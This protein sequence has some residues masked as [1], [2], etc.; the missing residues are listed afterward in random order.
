M[1]II[2]MEKKKKKHKAAII[3]LYCSK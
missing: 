2:H 3:W 1:W